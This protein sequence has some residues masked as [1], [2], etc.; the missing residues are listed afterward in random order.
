MRKKIQKKSKKIHTKSFGSSQDDF[1]QT[2]FA[3]F[4]V[5]DIQLLLYINPSQKGHYHIDNFQH[6]TKTKPLWSSWLILISLSSEFI[7]SQGWMFCFLIW[8]WLITECNVWCWLTMQPWNDFLC[9]SSLRCTSANSYQLM[10]KYK[11][12]NEKENTNTNTQMERK[13]QLQIKIH[14]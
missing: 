6:I 11:Y 12:T 14:K 5:T 4:F 8:C 7:I 13:L 9:R 10:H 3:N 2:K 1:V